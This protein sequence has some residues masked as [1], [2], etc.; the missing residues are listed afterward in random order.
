MRMMIWSTIFQSIPLLNYRKDTLKI[1]INESS[2]VHRL[3]F[4]IRMVILILPLHF[5]T[6]IC[7]K[8]LQLYLFW[9][10]QIVFPS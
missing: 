4:L 8:V 1:V 6:V 7:N 9:K 2:L 3:T 10:M 5:T